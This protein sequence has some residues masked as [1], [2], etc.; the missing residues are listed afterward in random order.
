MSDLSRHGIAPPRPITPFSATA[1][2]STISISY[3]LREPRQRI[4]ADAA[5]GPLVQQHARRAICRIRS[6]ACSSRAPTT[7]SA[8]SRSATH[9]A[10]EM[11]HQRLADA[12]C[13]GCAG[14]H[15]QV[16]QIDAGAPAEGGEIEEPER[17]ADRL[18]VPFGEVAEH[19][20]LLAEQRRIDHR[21]GRL[22]LVG[23]LLVFGKLAHEL[24]RESGLAGPRGADGQA[25]SAPS[26]RHLGLDVRVRA[27]SLRGRSPRS[28]T[29]TGPSRPD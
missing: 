3:P 13:R 6:T 5:D 12:P 9:F 15:E 23:E 24:Q 10:R 21:L 8:P 18:A 22:D 20:R 27:R 19:A 28:G 4:A 25:T 29:R 7:G 2:M 11:H 26:H 17:E 16:F 1:A 14:P